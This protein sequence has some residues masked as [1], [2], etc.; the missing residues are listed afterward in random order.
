MYKRFG[1]VAVVLMGL[2]LVGLNVFASALEPDPNVWGVVPER[3]EPSPNAEYVLV[4]ATL[5][6]APHPEDVMFRYF[7]RRLEELT[8]GRATTDYFADGILAPGG[9]R[10]LLEQVQSGDI[11]IA[12]VT[13]SLIAAV[14]PGHE[15]FQAPYLFSDTE[16]LHRVADSSE[17]QDLTKDDFTKAGHV[18]KGTWA[19]ARHL[20]STDPIKSLTDL[21]GVRVRTM[22]VP[23]IMDA[24]QA[25]GAVPTPLPWGEVYTGLQ[26]GLVHAAEGSATAYFSNRM[27]EVAKHFS[28]ISYMYAPITMIINA[29]AY[30]SWPADI[31]EAVD[32]ACQESVELVRE[33]YQTWEYE[34]FAE[35]EENGA[36]IYGPE[37]IPDL[38]EWQAAVA[39][40]GVNDDLFRRT[41]QEYLA[42]I[43]SY[44]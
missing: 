1:F 33:L 15:V 28:A 29:K 6:P 20:Y 26:T 31:R 2:L 34:V 37:D 10:D 8:N 12:R 38:N 35:M 18:Y 25:L 19:F 32:I 27:Y 22:E 13:D 43:E 17:F 41:G 40:A 5:H 21:S 23:V 44:Q 7:H 30:N 42:I 14:V 4:T 3:V 11:D 24:W 9:D 36:V 16:H 39:K